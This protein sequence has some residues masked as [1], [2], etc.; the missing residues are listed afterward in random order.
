MVLATLF[1]SMV[2][3]CLYTT[4]QFL[5]AQEKH[6][7]LEREITLY[8][9]GQQ[10]CLAQKKD[11]AQGLPYH[12][13]LNRQLNQAVSVKNIQDRIQKICNKN[14]KIRLNHIKYQSKRIINAPLNLSEVSFDIGLQ[15]PDHKTLLILIKKLTKHL[16]GIID[17]PKIATQVD[18]TENNLKGTILLTVI[19][20]IRE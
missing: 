5:N 16:P 11:I 8:H 1:I 17:T 10:A 13:F 20:P 3:V 6:Q 18:H 14:K 12:T 15:T 9:N 7:K 2:V 19:A 4:K